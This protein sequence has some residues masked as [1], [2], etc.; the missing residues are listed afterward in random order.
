VEVGALPIDIVGVVSN[1]TR[2]PDEGQIIEQDAAASSHAGS[3]CDQVVIGRPARASSWR[4]QSMHLHHSLFMNGKKK[5]VFP[6]SPDP[7]TKSV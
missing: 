7:S 1:H 6:P 2:L 3:S 5:T 4:G